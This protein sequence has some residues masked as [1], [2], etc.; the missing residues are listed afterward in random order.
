MSW[1]PLYLSPGVNTVVLFLLCLNVFTKKN[2]HTYPY[3]VSCLC[4]KMSYDEILVHIPCILYQYLA[5]KMLIN[6][7]KSGN[8]HTIYLRQSTFAVKG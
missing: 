5:M 8:S 6:Q 1:R 2:T 4:I 3:T 7:V